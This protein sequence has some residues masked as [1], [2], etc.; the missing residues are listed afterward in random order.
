MAVALG[1]N[2]ITNPALLKWLD[3]YIDPAEW[4][5]ELTGGEPGLYP[6]ISTLIPELAA[7]GFHGLVKTN[8]SL[9]M[10]KSANFQLVAAWHMDAEFP[11]NYDQILIIENPYDGWR[12]KV[13][14][15]NA[16]G[17]PY[18]T[19]LFD[20][21]FEGRKID[22]VYCKFNRKVVKCLH[23]NSGGKI[24][25]CAAVKP[26]PDQ[27]IFNMSPPAAK[28]VARDCPKC[29][30][31]NDVEKF[32]PEDMTKKFANDFGNWQAGG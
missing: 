5:I 22:S 25:P 11:Q 27:N 19:A 13:E 8:G 18:K 4:V 16:N 3:E 31:M 24:T 14:H 6:E 32:L 17:I 23:I 21:Q 15:C 10:P 1:K 12:E 28:E 2:L 7:R 9:P 30:N 20:R 26:I 29:K